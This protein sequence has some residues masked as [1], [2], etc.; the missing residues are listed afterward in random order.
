DSQEVVGV[1]REFVTQSEEDRRALGLSFQQIGTVVQ[2]VVSSGLKSVAEGL[3]RTTASVASSVS[4]ATT[5]LSQVIKEPLEEKTAEF[6]EMRAVVS[7]T[8]DRLRELVE[9]ISENSTGLSEVKAVL[10]ESVRSFSAASEMLVARAENSQEDISS[11]DSIHPDILAR[12][13]AGFGGMEKLGSALDLGVGALGEGTRTLSAV[14][15]S[16]Q[17]LFS[18]GEK[19]MSSSQSVLEDHSSVVIQQR[20]IFE[21][22]ERALKLFIEKLDDQVWRYNSDALEAVRNQVVS[23]A[24]EQLSGVYRAFEDTG[25]AIEQLPQLLGN[26]AEQIVSASDAFER[27]MVRHS[28]STIKQLEK[29]VAGIESAEISLKDSVAESGEMMTSSVKEALSNFEVLV[30][31]AVATLSTFADREK[32]DADISAEIKKTLEDWIGVIDR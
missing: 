12:M 32:R 19:I 24:T 14:V 3:D 18:L 2:E 27:M 21:E 23:G 22:S 29:T 4:D 11:N 15:E 8:F 7:E 17:Q 25:R 20:T 31:Q 16:A 28:E 1:L 9:K 26:T 30:S 10:E 13:D 6:G 5:T